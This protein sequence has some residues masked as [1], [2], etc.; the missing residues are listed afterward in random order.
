M[1]QPLA[2]Q[3]FDQRFQLEIAAWSQCLLTARDLLVVVLPG[4]LVRLGLGKSFTNYVL[5]THARSGVAR[6]NIRCTDALASG[7]ARP[8]GIFSERELNA[9]HGALEDHVVSVLAPAH[10]Q[11]GAL[12]TNGIGAAVQ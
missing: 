10:F 12:A 11:D 2:F 4:L 3:D 9:Q 1:H 8:L 6:R 7:I 5:D